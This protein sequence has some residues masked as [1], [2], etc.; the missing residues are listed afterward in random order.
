MRLAII[1]FNGT[2]CDP[3]TNALVLGAKELL[4]GLKSKGVRMV[5]VSKQVL[6]REGLPKQLGIADYFDEILFVEQKTGTLF[7]EIMNR[8]E[9]KPEN[10]YVIGDYPPSEIRAGNEAGAFTMHFI[11]G[12]YPSLEYENASDK[13][14]AQI[15]NLFDALQYIH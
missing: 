13:P 10:T 1:D 6:G 2:M 9:A 12:R 7:L 15:L 11:G 14:R 3:G 4:D 5:L 8:Y